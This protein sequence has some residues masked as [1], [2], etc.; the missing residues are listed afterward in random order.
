MPLK[1]EC[2]LLLC[3]SDVRSRMPSVLCK[4]WL[5]SSYSTSH[6]LSTTVICFLEHHWT[7]APKKMDKSCCRFAVVAFCVVCI[8][9]ELRCWDGQCVFV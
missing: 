5:D 1:M 7:G 2:E 6:V 4:A 3:S 9:V 8:G